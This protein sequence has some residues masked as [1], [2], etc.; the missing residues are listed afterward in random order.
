MR[1]S[2][3]GNHIGPSL[4]TAWVLPAFLFLLAFYVA[5]LVDSGI[6]SAAAPAQFET[7]YYTKLL[8]EAYYL[9]VI[10]NTLLLSAAVTLI[11]LVVGYPVAYLMVRV[12]PR[13]N[14]VIVFL[15][16]APLL[17]SIIMRTVGWRVL[18]ARRGLVNTMLADLGWIDQPLRMLDSPTA[19]VI[20]LVHLM[21]PFMVL[22]IAAVLQSLGT[23]ME[24]SARILG[25]GPLNTF[26][27]I[28]LPL[29]IDGIATGTIIVFMLTTGSFVTLLLLGGGSFQTLP[30]LIYQQFNA[31]RDLGFASAISNLLLVI[32]LACLYL[33]LRLIRRPGA[34]S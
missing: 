21:C 25:A 13:W 15:L 12:S 18:L 24:E 31:T 3:F 20:G 16:V 5:P 1:K 2:L 10:G 17:T 7:G 23:R 22:S 32:A 26:F 27:R 6:R 11:C 34:N 28:T 4:P 14:T 8:T 33:Q 30:L 19:V 9:G 29:S